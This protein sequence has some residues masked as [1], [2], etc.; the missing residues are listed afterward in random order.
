MRKPGN[1]YWGVVAL[2]GSIL[3]LILSVSAVWMKYQ[4]T[5]EQLQAVVTLL[6]RFIGPAIVV[7]LLVLVVCGA[8][9]L[10]IFRKFILPTRKIA[11][12]IP[13]INIPS[14]YPN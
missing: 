6:G 5:S 1:H 4:L 7:T 10:I 2:S 11:D 8:T 3:I 12:E 9:V 13:L 14:F